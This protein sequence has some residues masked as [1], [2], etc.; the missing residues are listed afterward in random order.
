MAE[1][2]DPFRPL[3][4][5]TLDDEHSGKGKRKSYTRE[6]K[7]KVVEYYRAHESNLYKTSKTFQ[8]N[9]KT[10]L[11][12][13]KD[14]KIRDG[15]EK[16]SKHTKHDRPAK[17]PDVEEKLRTEYREL[18]KKGLKVKGWW[19]PTRAKQ[20]VEELHPD[21]TFVF[22]NTWFAGFKTCS[23]ISLRRSTNTCQRQPAD[24]KS[25]IQG[26]H[27]AIRREA[28]NGESVGQL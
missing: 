8:L 10:V 22:S 28:R 26:F 25:A 20:I 12:W 1:A 15:T 5:C 9:T 17:Y 7:L 11:R 18:R 2:P 21:K 27:Q 13:M 19:F 4:Q 23:H 14:A 16:G 6:T 3:Q 24:K